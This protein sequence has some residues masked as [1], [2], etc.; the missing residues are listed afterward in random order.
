M[1][2]KR[3]FAVKSSARVKSGARMSKRNKYIVAIG[4]LGLVALASL[5]AVTITGRGLWDD[6]WGSPPPD[7]P[8]DEL[9]GA[10]DIE[11]DLIMYL[12]FDDEVINSDADAGGDLSGNNNNGT[13][14][15]ADSMP[16]WIPEG[17][18]DGAYRFDGGDYIIIDDA[19]SLDIITD[20]TIAMWVNPSAPIARSFLL[21]K[22]AGGDWTVPYA[23]E[24][25]TAETATC[26]APPCAGAWLG[27][28]NEALTL[29]LGTDTITAGWHHVALRVDHDIAT[30]WLDGVEGADNLFQ[31]MR[32]QNNAKIWLGVYPENDMPHSSPFYYNGEM[33]EVY[34]YNR[35]LTEGEIGALFDGGSKRVINL[36]PEDANFTIENI[37]NHTVVVNGTFKYQINVT[38]PEGVN[39]T[40]F[41]DTIWLPLDNETGLINGTIDAPQG[42]HE[43]LVG[44]EN[45]TE[46]NITTSFNLT[47]MYATGPSICGDAVVEGVEE[48]EGNETALCA[49]FTGSPLCSGTATCVAAYCVWD[50]SSCT[51][52]CAPLVQPDDGDW[53]SCIG[54][55]QTMTTYECDAG[56][57]NWVPVTDFRDCEDEGEGLGMWLYIIIGGGV[58]VLLGGLFALWY[59][60]LGPNGML[61]GG[62]YN[63]MTGGGGM[64]SGGLGGVS[65]PAGASGASPDAELEKYTGG[66]AAPKKPATPKAPA[67]KAP[68]PPAPKTPF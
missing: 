52:A 16:T 26:L 48:C 62:L 21:S 15:A 42:T 43:V 68:A 22:R 54:G 32:Q 18:Y 8:E 14:A 56:T 17:K 44:A 61:F 4:V 36:A 33:D 58:L 50:T 34:I 29:R 20:L 45:D 49:E 41:T 55:E 13:L 65:A 1:N 19:D 60:Y 64:S 51:C 67:P 11:S 27:G 3:R 63:S 39:I 10:V 9:G 47:I 12:P 5:L 59:F 2:K 6:F 30:M 38:A 53:S 28:G 7:A 66:S 46:D 31:G 35:A 40:Y 25:E 23:L 24:I 57:G 37:T